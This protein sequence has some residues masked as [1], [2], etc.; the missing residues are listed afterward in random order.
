M[1]EIPIEVGYRSYIRLL[2]NKWDIAY[3]SKDLYFSHA[4]KILEPYYD[5]TTKEFYGAETNPTRLAI[6][7]FID[8][9]R[10]GPGLYD[11][12][13]FNDLPR[14]SKNYE[15]RIQVRKPYRS[16][17]HQQ[18]HPSL[19]EA[20]REKRYRSQEIKPVVRELLAKTHSQKY[21][22][23]VED[24]P[25]EKLIGR[26]WT[27]IFVPTPV[28]YEKVDELE[29]VGYRQLLM[30]ACIESHDMIVVEPILTWFYAT[31][32]IQAFWWFKFVV[33]AMYTLSIIHCCHKPHRWERNWFY[34]L[35]TSIVHFGL[36]GSMQ[37]HPLSQYKL[38]DRYHDTESLSE[39]KYF[40]EFVPTIIHKVLVL[41]RDKERMIEKPMKLIKTLHL[42][43]LFVLGYNYMYGT[44]HWFGFFRS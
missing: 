28:D 40:K 17:Q 24:H 26:S 32:W 43:N 25:Y 37:M 9:F 12:E 34:F 41:F 4:N 19:C 14:Y 35:M 30:E 16:G 27:Y 22:L 18:S 2:R 31:F 11:T 6:V 7:K 44:N 13:K 33:K 36:V 5:M 21:S 15:K 8:Q 42:I 38:P 20:M 1:T 39:L 29:R 3:H 10:E 23:F